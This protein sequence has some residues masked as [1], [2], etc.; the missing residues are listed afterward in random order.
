VDGAVEAAAAYLH[1]N[2]RVRKEEEKRRGGP[3]RR[4]HKKGRRS[5]W[6]RG[7]KNDECKIKAREP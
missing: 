3:R 7:G 2:Q 5:R 1:S 6:G 4:G